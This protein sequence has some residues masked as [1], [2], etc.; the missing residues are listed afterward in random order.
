MHLETKARAGFLCLRQSYARGGV[1]ISNTL[2]VFLLGGTN[3]L[4]CIA[5][6]TIELVIYHGV[7]SLVWGGLI[8]FQNETHTHTL[9]RTHDIYLNTRRLRGSGRA[10]IF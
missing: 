4:Q 1:E 6:Y 9:T 10:K 7:P 5:L 3:I 8:S 2:G